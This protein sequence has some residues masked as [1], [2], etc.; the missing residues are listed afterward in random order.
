M[1]RRVGAWN[2][3]LLALFPWISH[4][5]L[6]LELQPAVRA[7]TF[8]V[9]QKKPTDDPLTYEKPLPLELIPYI[10]RTDLY[11]SVGTAFAL[12]HN[13]YVTAAHV[14]APGVNS[15][16]GA[17]ALRAA[18]GAVYPIDRILKFSSHGDFVVFSLGDDPAPKGFT[19]KREA[20]IDTAVYAVGN[21]LGEGIVIR[22]GAF[23][24]ET[25]EE[26]DGAWKWIRFS[27]AASPGN[28]GGPLL[29]DAGNV[30]GIVLRKSANENLNYS[31]PIGLVLDAPDDKATFDQR[32]LT[33]LPYM[34]GRRTYAYRDSFKLP[35]AWPEFAK[36][37]AA[38][39]SK[40]FDAALAELLKTYADT[41]FARGVGADT[42]LY[43]Q[44]GDPFA[45]RLITQQSDDT[46]TASILDCCST[47]LR[48]DGIMTS[49]SVGGALMIRLHRSGN[50]SD[51][52]FYG[53]SKAF[54]DIAL[55]GLAFTR[56]VGSDQVRIT[57]LGAAQSDAVYTDRYGRIWQERVWPMPYHDV[58]AAALLLPTPDG[59]AGMVQITPSMVLRQ[60]QAIMRLMAEQF[61]V[62]YAGTPLQWQSYLKR[63]ALL[64]KPLTRV[65]LAQKPDWQLKTPRFEFSVPAKTF[66][67]GEQGQIGMM[68]DFALEGATLTWDVLGASFSKDA[69]GKSSVGLYR[70]ARPPKMAK[71]ELRNRYA[72][73]AERHAPF[74]QHVM[75]ESA[76]EY[77]VNQV[78][79][80][81]GERP[82][83][84]SSGVV[85]E[86]GVRLAGSTA[87]ME[88]PQVLQESAATVHI[89]EH[90]VGEDVEIKHEQTAS[91]DAAPPADTDFA[92]AVNGKVDAK[93][94]HDIRGRTLSED[95]RQYIVPVSGDYAEVMKRSQALQ[96]YWKSVPVLRNN[97]DLWDAF[98]EKN[99]LRDQL[100]RPAVLI[101]ETQLLKALESTP[102]PEWGRLSIKLAQAY[103]E[104]RGEIA[105][106]HA[107]QLPAAY[108]ER[109]LPCPKPPEK[110]SASDRPA[111][112]KPLNFT[113]EYYPMAARKDNVEGFVVLSIQVNANGCGQQKGIAVSSGSDALDQAALGFIDTAEFLP[114]QRGGARIA[115]VYKTNVR[116]KLSDI[117]N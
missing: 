82:G 102:D 91:T 62:S 98:I 100:H 51:D 48:D 4:A 87:Y 68:M 115:S 61:T 2:I 112:A 36:A 7:S 63:S 30:L 37:Y 28:S 94:G 22:D 17:P 34:R 74:D 33:A 32:D 60:T 66:P 64:P 41:Q 80:V 104:E 86:V 57:S 5:G 72:D 96:D 99:R 10:E 84:I 20:K 29:D 81:Q 79:D 49:G 43:Q 9:V 25:P 111:L 88:A 109:Q 45:P 42:I 54:M 6:P 50:A 56:P 114:A 95:L 59:Y 103:I 23:T 78:L 11:R 105:R 65:T 110:S 12:G 16:F 52:K 83:S 35:L 107:D 85:Y 117:Q 53:D 47:N 113:A 58:Y 18:N 67:V 73:V 97:R 55:K 108:V 21:A 19:V 40:H 3:G 76:D 24:S 1:K 71:Q 93:F 26:Q 27:A 90:G 44:D 77:V 31:L 8:E 69:E 46:W 116:F 70:N 75:R 89:L 39:L 92:A 106:L 38:T 15:Q 101:A 14:L 13:Q